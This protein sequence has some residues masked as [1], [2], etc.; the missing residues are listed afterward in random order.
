MA[1]YTP[2][3][4]ELLARRL[5]PAVRRAFEQAIAGVR[6]QVQLDLLASLLQSGQVDAVLEA[7]GFDGERFSP[8][9][10]QVRQAFATGAEVGM[11]ELPTLSL[12]QQVRGR[13]NPAN[14][15]PLL[16]FGF[17]MRNRGVESWLQS[18]SSRL[19]TGV[20]EDQRVLVR[21]LLTR[22]M[23]S[24]TNPRQTALELVGRVGETG[25]RS[26]GVVGLTAQQAQF[27]ANVRQQLASGDPSQ[28]AEYFSR[29]RRDRRLDG[30]VSR[31]IKA[32]QP[33]APADVD[34]IAARYADRL[35]AL[36][37]E[38]IARTESL[39][40]MAAGR[41][42]AFRQQIESGRL[43]PENVEGTWSATGDDRT[44]HSHQAMNGQ[45]R[46]FGE[47]FQTPS[48][49]LVRFPGDTSLG[50]GPEETIGCRCMKKY[51]V[52]MAAEVKRGQ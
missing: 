3:E 52:N 13:Y 33:V 16:R 26:G 12:R 11:K 18:N 40:A 30:I 35:L 44:R 38:M 42:E 8:L 25:R 49:A 45:V 10:E 22:G 28:M 23:A 39:T 15:T 29:K 47:P 6:S 32:G 48:G 37:G 14:D 19:I 51:R 34:K 24:G 21:Q 50:A 41:E 43:A 36:R 1:D 20:V 31:A 5:E 27:V 2:R 7:L 4:L 17:D 9:A 46:R